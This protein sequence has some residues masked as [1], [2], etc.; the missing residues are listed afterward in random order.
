MVR[1]KEWSGDTGQM[2]VPFA[3]RADVHT[4]AKWLDSGQITVDEIRQLIEQKQKE[5]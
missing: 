4:V 1:P 2:R 5:G 3:I